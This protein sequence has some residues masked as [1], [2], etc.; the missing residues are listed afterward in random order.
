LSIYNI[1]ALPGIDTFF[2]IGIIR[3]KIL[4]IVCGMLKN[5]AMYEPESDKRNRNKKRIEKPEVR[6]SIKIED[7]NLM[8]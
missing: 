2:P 6:K 4:R 1:P 7:Y 8:T 5:N 3:H